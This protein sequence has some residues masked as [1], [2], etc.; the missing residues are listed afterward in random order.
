MRNRG[1]SKQCVW[2]GSCGYSCCGGGRNTDA[3]ADCHSDGDGHA[4]SQ[5]HCNSI[6][7]GHAT[8]DANTQVGAIGKAAPHASAAALDPAAPEDFQ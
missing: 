7:N 5:P 4:N 2:V 8:T 6:G 3:D 1:P